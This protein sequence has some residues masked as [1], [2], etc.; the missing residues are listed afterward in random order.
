MV[1]GGSP[2]QRMG[3][4]EGNGMGRG[5]IRRRQAAGLGPGEAVSR[6]CVSGMQEGA[7][8]G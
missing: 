8:E 2:S 5:A 1:G 6:L 7:R 3:Q 4:K